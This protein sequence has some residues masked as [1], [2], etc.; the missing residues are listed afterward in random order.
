MSDRIE[1]TEDRLYVS[2]HETRAEVVGDIRLELVEDDLV[3]PGAFS[4]RG[5]RHDLKVRQ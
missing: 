3:L 4:P 2:V 5:R 1:I